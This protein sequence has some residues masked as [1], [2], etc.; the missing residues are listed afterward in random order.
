MQAFDKMDSVGP[1][2]N[3]V[4]E[5]DKIICGSRIKSTLTTSM[6]GKFTNDV[7]IANKS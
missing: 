1:C 5:I 2:S 6:V 3:E 4:G 7:L